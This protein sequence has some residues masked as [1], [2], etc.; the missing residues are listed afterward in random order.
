MYGKDKIIEML[1]KGN[2]PGYS[3]L[4]KMSSD[5]L[6]DVVLAFETFLWDKTRGEAYREALREL[7][8]ALESY[9]GKD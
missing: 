8:E 3:D 5:V 1:K 4:E 2:E 9:W 6:A 7:G